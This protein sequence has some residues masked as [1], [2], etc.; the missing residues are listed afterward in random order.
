MTHD[1]QSSPYILRASNS[2]ILKPNANPF[3]PKRGVNMLVQPRIDSAGTHISTVMSCNST[4]N[5]TFCTEPIREFNNREKSNEHGAEKLL[6]N[7]R[8][9]NLNRLIIGHLNINSIRHKVEALKQIIKKNLDLLI[10]SETKLDHNFPNNQFYMD[11]YRLIRE[12]REKMV[13]MAEVLSYL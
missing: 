8:L 9:K 1:C 2:F 12:D 6:N 5:F 13:N 4:E 3:I 7:L 10:V 11:G